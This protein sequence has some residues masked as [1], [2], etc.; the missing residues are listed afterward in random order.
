MIRKKYKKV[1][2]LAPKI[3]TAQ[4]LLYINAIIWFGFGIYVLVDMIRTGNTA[5][6][7]L[8]IS[9]FLLI[10]VAAMVFCAITIGRRDSWAYYFSLFII[11]VNIIFTR[12]GHFDVFDLLAFIADLVILAFLLFMGKAYLKES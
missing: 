3:L 8:L 7:I 2:T 4:F 6:V 11:I 12:L 1:D 9:F 5:S 10:N